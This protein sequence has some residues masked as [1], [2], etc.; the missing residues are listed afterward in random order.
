[1]STWVLAFPFKTSLF[2]QEKSSAVSTTS[3][4]AG[5]KNVGQGSVPSKN[6]QPLLLYIT[7]L[8]ACNLCAYNIELSELSSFFM[9]RS[10]LLQKSGNTTMCADKISASIDATHVF[11]DRTKR[12]RKTRTNLDNLDLGWRTNNLPPLDQILDPL[13]KRLDLVWG[14]VGYC[15]TL[16]SITKGVCWPWYA[17]TM[18]P[19]YGYASLRTVDY[20]FSHSS[21][22]SPIMR[23]FLLFVP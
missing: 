15:D 18:R 9:F 19:R 10:L 3:L 14:G 21:C 23:F 11:P 13:Q 6:I 20:V 16:A 1:M 7:L 17:Y 4:L 8:P 12:F 2:Y 22:F 5:S